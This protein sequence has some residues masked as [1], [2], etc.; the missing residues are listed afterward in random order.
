MADDSEFQRNLSLLQQGAVP[1][2]LVPANGHDAGGLGLH[3]RNSL[4]RSVYV[5]PDAGEEEDGGAGAYE[6]KEQMYED[7]DFGAV[8]C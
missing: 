7:S 1:D 8:P 6:E 5:P 4:T 3:R 2:H